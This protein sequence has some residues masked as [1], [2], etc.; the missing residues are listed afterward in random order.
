MTQIDLSIGSMSP[1][2]EYQTRL[3]ARCAEYKARWP[4]KH[5]EHERI[6]IASLMLPLKYHRDGMPSTVQSVVDS[7]VRERIRVER[8]WK[9]ERDWL[10]TVL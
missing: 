9:T 7:L 10:L 3:I 1:S 2:D 6:V 4:E 5:Q 8:E